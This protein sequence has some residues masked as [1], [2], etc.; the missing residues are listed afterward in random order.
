MTDNQNI[1][2]ETSLADDIRAAVAKYDNRDALFALL[3]LVLGWLFVR[4]TLLTMPVGLGMTLFTYACCVL[5]VVRLRTSGK[6]IS[7]EGVMW[8]CAACVFGTV[9]S[10]VLGD[11]T[12]ALSLLCAAL[13]F[14][15]LCMRG[16]YVCDT[17]YLLLDAVWVL[18]MPFARMFGVFTALCVPFV[19]GNKKSRNIATVLGGV[20]IAA[21][22]TCVVVFLLMRADAAFEGVMDRVLDFVMPDDFD[23]VVLNVVNVILGFPCGLYIFGAFAAPAKGERSSRESRVKCR[24]TVEGMRIASPWLVCAVFAPLCV[25]YLVFFIS[26]TGYLPGM[27]DSL[28]AGFSIAEYARRGFFDLCKVAGINLALIACVMIFARRSAM[29]KAAVTVLAS[30]TVGLAFTALIKLWMY[31]ER[32]GL[33]VNRIYPAAFMAVLIVC[34]V[35][36]VVSLYRPIRL[37]TICC[38][39]CVVVSGALFCAEPD[40]IVG[41][42]N[43]HMYAEGK[44]DSLDLHHYMS[45]SPSALEFIVPFT[46]DEEIGDA[47]LFVIGHRYREAAYRGDGLSEWSFF[48]FR[49]R[50]LSVL[51]EPYF[52]EYSERAA[53][54]VCG[55]DW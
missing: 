54:I 45:L 10:F 44:L 52:E 38:A 13:A 21:V 11:D 41:M 2:R 33:T 23:D 19:S 15:M 53:E 4:F 31:I 28:P 9:P 50:R 27:S 48:N 40:R 46:D 8:F 47:V 26:Q 49:A 7:P 39:V 25:V 6:R 42:Y 12:A 3:S 55:I 22:P 43:A 36:L 1:A 24:E 14:L 16:S 20:L 34:F 32:F 18:F 5:A 17:G 35:L 51:L 37:I 29:M 30:F